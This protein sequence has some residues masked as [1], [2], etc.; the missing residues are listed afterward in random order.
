MSED[1]WIAVCTLILVAGAVGLASIVGIGIYN[2]NE[3][4]NK[5]QLECVQA[6]AEVKWDQVAKESYCSKK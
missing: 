3:Q 4:D 6:G 2:A 5:F 1:G